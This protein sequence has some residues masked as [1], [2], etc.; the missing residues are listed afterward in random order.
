MP[1]EITMPQ[2]SDTMTEGTV[3]KWLKKEGDK[4]KSGDKIAE[5]ET[6]K[7]VMEM[8]SFDSGTLAAIVIAAGQK[9]A[10]GA[11]LAVVATGKEDPAEVKKQFASGGKKPAAPA[12]AAAKAPA[13]TSSHGSMESAV[14]G[15]IHE[16]DHIG[17]SS[18]RA[19]STATSAAS[20]STAIAAPPARSGNGNQRVKISPLAKRIAADRN[21]DPGSLIGTGPGGR[22]VKQDVL[23]AGPGS[24]GGRGA[25]LSPTAPPPPLPRPGSGEKQVIPLTKMRAAIGKAL[26]ASKQNIPHFYETIDA[27]VEELVLQRAKLN[28]MLEKE[29]I[30]LSIGDFVSKAIAMS[31]IAHPALNA[32]FNGAEVTRYG[33][34]HLGMAVAIPD[35]LIV[36]VLR[37]VH[38][39]G[40]KEIRQRSVDLID[41]AR[42]QRLRQE[43]MSGATFTV[44]NLGT[45]GVREFSAIINP[46][47]VAI[48]AVASAE[49]RPA[50][51]N[52]Q[53]V[54]RTMLTLTLSADHRVVDG[55]TAAD[56]LKTLRSLLEEPGMMLVFS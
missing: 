35:G 38:L 13:A 55:A 22:I 47:Q 12:P 30:R 53:I 42:A 3:V 37:N 16:M 36:P 32:T 26:V 20:P 11:T 48:L 7:A 46:P 40:L 52:G 49:K 29:K 1:A 54:P 15:E 10:V 4:V 44:S 2:L 5:V 8:E 43:E 28:E 31:L 19:P 33:D 56:F 50:V 6:D 27:D 45:Y 51:R 21:I 17:H 34:V 39:M 14:S 41:R 23:T 18:A 25:G 24:S 9:V